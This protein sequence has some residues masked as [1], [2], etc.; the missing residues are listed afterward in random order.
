[1]HLLKASLSYL[2]N[3]TLELASET[4]DTIMVPAKLAVRLSEERTLKISERTRYH[5]AVYLQ[6][7]LRDWRRTG[8]G[9]YTG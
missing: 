9:P 6:P 4:V 5:A 1:M 7:G 2:L 3:D 8:K